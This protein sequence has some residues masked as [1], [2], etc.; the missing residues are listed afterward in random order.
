MNA[1]SS[2]VRT[3]AEKRSWLVVHFGHT[4]LAF[5]LYWLC[6][7]PLY[8]DIIYRPWKTAS[9]WLFAGLAL[10][11]WVPVRRA[12]RHGASF[13]RFPY[14]LAVALAVRRLE[15]GRR[16]GTWRRYRSYRLIQTRWKLIL[17][18]SYFLPLMFGSLCDGA[19][20]LHVQWPFGIGLSGALA[21][22]TTLVFFV[23][24]AV[25]TA[26]YSLESRRWGCPIE[27]VES[28]VTGWIVCLACYP[29]VLVISTRL[30]PLRPAGRLFSPDAPWQALCSIL[31]S[32]FLLVYMI[33]IVSQGLRFANL[34]Y[35]GTT[36]RGPYAFVRHP[37]YAAKLLSWLF[38]W[39][40]ALGSPLNLLSFAGWVG[41]YVGRALTEERF[42]L[43]FP[44]YRQYCARVRWRMI[45][46]V[47]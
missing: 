10:F 20:N 7:S 33:G 3:E 45:P 47:W 24:S 6:Q 15:P 40:P 43:R 30:L 9:G 19:Y 32:I 23:D 14:F 25:A 27:A 28:S 29:P 17:L 46:G 11:G 37:Q 2:S 13:R 31:A 12:M 16:H 38:V 21:L 8:S 41:I 35:R 26:G 1:R 44:D 5:A 39:L 18:K 4:A 34:T 36:T 42:L 22:I